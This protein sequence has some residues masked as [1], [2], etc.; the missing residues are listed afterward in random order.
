MRK[1]SQTRQTGAAKAIEVI[2]PA[3]CIDANA[4]ISDEF[5]RVVF[6]PAVVGVNLLMLNGVKNIKVASRIYAKGTGACC[7]LINSYDP[8]AI[9][10]TLSSTRR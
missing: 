2:R 4:N 6:H 7:A 8:H 10:L 1:K 5:F 9:S 3:C